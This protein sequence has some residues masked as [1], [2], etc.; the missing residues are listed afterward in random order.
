[1]SEL[2]RRIFTEFDRSALQKAELFRG[3]GVASISD[4]MNRA[5]CMRPEIKP[6][7][8][9]ANMQML[10]VALTVMTRC[11]DNLLVQKALEMAQPGD[12]IV[13]DA[14]ADMSQGMLG[15]IMVA[16]AKKR[17]VRGY[18]IDGIVRDIKGMRPL[19]DVPVYARGLTPRGPWFDGPGEI[20]A[21]ISCG[22]VVVNP[23]DIIVGDEDGVIV[24]PPAYAEQV[25]LEARRIEERDPVWLAQIEQYG[26]KLNM[27]WLDETIQSRKFVIHEGMYSH[28][29]EKQ[30]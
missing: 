21:P 19:A 3:I 18:V 8:P 23:G 7:L 9:V 24:I 12:V 27:E 4:C 11:A 13:V 16:L 17:G 6:V 26:R 28:E 14:G 1:M 20:N 5:F 25:A 30:G 29:K 22:G 2:G 15:D 10:G